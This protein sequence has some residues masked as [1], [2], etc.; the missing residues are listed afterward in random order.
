MLIIDIYM[1]VFFV[2]LV[3]G[4][5]LRAATPNPSHSGVIRFYYLSLSRSPRTAVRNCAPCYSLSIEQ[6]LSGL[7]CSIYG[8]Y[9][10]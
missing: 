6:W 5:V 8:E 3:S 7:C 1:Y 10:L 9:D 2:D 4:Y